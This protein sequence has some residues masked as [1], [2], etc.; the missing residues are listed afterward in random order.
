MVKGSLNNALLLKH[1]WYLE[2][3][4]E[5][6]Q[7][8]KIHR[9]FG[10]QVDVGLILKDSVSKKPFRNLRKLGWRYI[11]LLALLLVIYTK[12]IVTLAFLVYSQTTPQSFTLPEAFICCRILLIF[13]S[14]K[15]P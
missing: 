15:W 10:L 13:L 5:Q 3:K 9:K 6:L 4:N 8:S 7:Y 1:V 2:R 12:V 14:A 11:P